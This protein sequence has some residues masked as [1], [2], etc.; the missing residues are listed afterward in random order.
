MR[1][2]GHP[3]PASLSIPGPPFPEKATNQ[4][5]A[6]VKLTRKDEVEMSET[7]LKS[8]ASQRVWEKLH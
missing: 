8:G 2:A 1:G 7:V 6:E 3:T 4:C 5:T